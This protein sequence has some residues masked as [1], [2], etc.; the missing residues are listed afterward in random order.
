MKDVAR[1][2]CICLLVLIGSAVY[3]QADDAYWQHD[4]AS[5]GDWFVPGNWSTGLLP[6]PA[7]T[8]YI[9][10][11]GTALVGS[12]AI[13]ISELQLGESFTGGLIQSGGDVVVDS[14]AVAEGSQYGL[15]GGTLQINNDFDLHGTLDFGGG[16][17]TVTISDNA[18][19]NW[20]QGTLLNASNASVS[21]GDGSVMLLDP[22]STLTLLWGFSRK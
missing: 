7:D 18:E 1:L 21:A 3:A 11:D 20:S 5:Q 16:T 19:I 2:G 22:A 6:G 8:A 14:V 10:N 12:G 4:P 9:D 13:G 17:A 15:T